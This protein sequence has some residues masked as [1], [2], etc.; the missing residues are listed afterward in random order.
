MSQFGSRNA[1]I[2]C[3]ISKNNFRKND[4]MCRETIIQI[5]STQSYLFS[6]LLLVVFVFQ[7]LARNKKVFNFNKQ[8]FV[9]STGTYTLVHMYCIEFLRNKQSKYQLVF[10]KGI[11]SIIQCLQCR[12]FVTPLDCVRTFIAV[13]YAKIM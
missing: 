8:F 11:D 7:D 12:M 13:T 3:C 6:L 10:E 5:C 4:I 9:T 1:S 2:W